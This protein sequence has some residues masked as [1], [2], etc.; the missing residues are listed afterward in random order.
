MARMNKMDKIACS[1]TLSSV[2]ALRALQLSQHSDEVP[3]MVWCCFHSESCLLFQP[4]A[5]QNLGNGWSAQVTE[6][7]ASYGCRYPKH[8]AACCLTKG[9]FPHDALFLLAVQRA[10]IQQHT[11]QSRPKQHIP[12]CYSRSAAALKGTPP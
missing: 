8:S 7:L 4:A 11:S 1:S 6:A 10:A 9:T 12:G 5:A 2:K 3:R